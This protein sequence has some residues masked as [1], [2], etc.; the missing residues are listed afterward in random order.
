MEVLII[1]AV[2]FLII[3]IASIK[4]VNQA[5][6]YVIERLGKFS[7]VAKPG[8]TLIIPVIDKVRAVV[9]LKK[10]IMDINHKRL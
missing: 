7:R 2:I 9:S 8:L 6:V 10:Q 5:E 3:V 1:L 4:I